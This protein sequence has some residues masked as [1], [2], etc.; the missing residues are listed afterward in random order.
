MRKR[1]LSILL[2]VCMVLRLAPVGVFAEGKAAKSVT[3]NSELTDALADDSADTVKLE[4]DIHP[5][6]GETF[7]VDREVTLDLNGY[8]MERYGGSRFFDVK[9]GGHL[10][11]IDSRPTVERKFRIDNNGVWWDSERNGT[12]IVCGGVITGGLDKRGGGGVYVY[13]GGRLTMNG[14][15]IVGCQGSDSEGGGVYVHGDG[16]FEMNDGAAII[17]CVS[18]REGGGVYVA[19]DGTFTMNGGNISDCKAYSG[20]GVYSSGQFTMNNGTIKNCAGGLGDAVYNNSG[21]ALTLNGTII[22]ENGDDNWTIFN[23]YGNTVIIGAD[24]DIRANMYM[25][26]GTLRADGG[27]FRGNLYANSS[28]TVTVDED[29]TQSTIFYGKLTGNCDYH[30]DG[31]A[32]TYQVNG[33]DYATQFLRSG[34]TALKPDD[35]AAEDGYVFAGWYNS[36]TVHNFIRPITENITLTAKWA[37][38]VDKTADFTAP[39]GGAAA[40]ALLNS[41]KNGAEDSMW[42][43]ATNTLTL[44]GVSMATTATTAVKLPDGATVILADG[45]ENHIIGGGAAVSENGRKN[46]VVYIYGMYAAGALTIEGEKDGTGTLFVSSGEHTNAGDALTYSTALYADG[47]LTVKGGVTTAQGGKASNGDVAFSLGIQLSE[48][49]SLSVSGGTLI[50]IGGESFDTKDPNRVSTSFSEGVDIFRGNVTISGSGK[51]IAATVPD[52]KDEGLSLGLYIIQGSLYV[53]DSATFTSTTNR[54]IDISGGDIKLSG[55]K[56]S[57]FHA[58]GDGVAVSV[59]RNDYYNTGNG[60]FEITGGELACVGGLYMDAPR[61]DGMGILSII[62]GKLTTGSIYGPDKL[63]ISNSTVVSGRINANTVELQSG[64]LT[65][66][67]PVYKNEYTNDLYASH[68]IYCKKLTVSGGMLDAAWSWGEY[69]PIVFSPDSYWGYAHPLIKVLNGTSSFGGGSVILDTGCSGNTAI[70]TEKLNLSGGVR[71]SGYTN[72]D[73]SDTYIQSDGNTFVKFTVYPADYTKV[74]EAITKANALN[75]DDYKDFSAVEAA[76]KAVV[77]GKNLDEQAAVDAMAKTIEAAIA[78]LEYK[79]ADYSK[80]N[81]AIAKANALNKDEYKDFSAVQAAM[82]AVVRGKNLDEQAAVDAMAKTIEAAIAALEYK[83][84]DYS[85]VNAAL[86]KANALNKDDYQDF[87]AVQAAV[88]AVVPGKNVTEQAAVDAMAKAIEDAINALEIKPEPGDK[89][90]QTGDT[91]SLMLWIALLYISGG[92]GIC[93]TVVSRK[94]NHNSQ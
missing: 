45:T 34:K 91:G 26:C 48:G 29:V 42:D 88:D 22:Q 44:K 7:T 75:K 17:G 94:K 37:K 15:S 24:A 78:A 8:M 83:D 59:V 38:L 1:I 69:T 40:I 55:G 33:K 90:P 5:N 49:H 76:I 43:N 9:D 36:G 79:D 35:P 52:M 57:A 80:V 72:E 28:I 60:N 92:A 2:T 65:I 3:T 4:A 67:E 77:R 41:A 10:T 23:Q 32:V 47:D 31:V 50:G 86:D 13:A 56:I 58:A 14:G 46:V 74:N 30:I 25:S 70:K 85:K 71:G 73:G 18:N 16:V 51:L 11:I 19:A 21:T 81:A 87:S 39:D 93:A 84:A 62:N 54:A 82:D 68:A 89:S 53:S 12:E 20:G 61:T 6:I 63:T 27:V 66:R 64:S